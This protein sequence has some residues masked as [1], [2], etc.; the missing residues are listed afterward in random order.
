MKDYEANLKIIIRP[1]L[2]AVIQIGLIDPS[3]DSLKY[4]KFFLQN[5]QMILQENGNWSLSDLIDKYDRLI[6]IMKSGFNIRL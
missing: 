4:S 1:D 5:L 2:N 3:E 6:E